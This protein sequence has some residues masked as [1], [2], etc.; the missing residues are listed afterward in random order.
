MS[1]ADVIEKCGTAVMTP[2][3][4]PTIDDQCILNVTLNCFK[5]MVESAINSSA[6][7]LLQSGGGRSPKYQSIAP[8]L[9]AHGISL[10]ATGKTLVPQ[11][12]IRDSVPKGKYWINVPLG[13]YLNRDQ[14]SQLNKVIKLSLN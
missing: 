6:S 5:D 7:S 2:E 9:V 11:G 13:K 4:C 14:L 12:L 1:V 8:Y 10:P 3:D